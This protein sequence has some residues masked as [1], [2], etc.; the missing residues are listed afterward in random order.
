MNTM[1][2][3]SLTIPACCRNITAIFCTA[4]AF[5]AKQTIIANG[6]DHMVTAF[7]FFTIKAF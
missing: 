1:F 6:A 2:V 5:A 7:A 3:A 4:E